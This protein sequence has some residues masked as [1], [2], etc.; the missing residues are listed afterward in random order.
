MESNQYHTDAHTL[1]PFNTLQ[2]KKV[3]LRTTFASTDTSYGGVQLSCC[4]YYGN[5]LNQY[6]SAELQAVSNLYSKPIAAYTHGSPRRNR[7]VSVSPVTLLG[8][9]ALMVF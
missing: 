6:S 2:L 9:V 1:L 4:E 8:P 5:V 3:R 7:V